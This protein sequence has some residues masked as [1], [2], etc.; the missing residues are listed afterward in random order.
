MTHA[1]QRAT[2]A[3]SEVKKLSLG[4]RLIVWPFALLTRLWL[5]TLRMPCLDEERN[6][7]RD[8]DDPTVVIVWHNRLA[9]AAEYVRRYRR[10]RRCG[11]DEFRGAGRRPLNRAGSRAETNLE[12][13]PPFI[14]SPTPQ[15]TALPRPCQSRTSRRR[16]PLR[17]T[18]QRRC[19]HRKQGF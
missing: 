9:L 1:P 12:Y 8:V 7:L 10:E 5:K 11:C 14:P 19:V 17:S 18:E 2:A 4:K 3:G 6:D 15:I 13:P 16:R